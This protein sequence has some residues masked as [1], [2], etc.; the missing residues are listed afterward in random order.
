MYENTIRKLIEAGFGAA[1]DFEGATEAEIAAVEARFGRPLPGAY[2]AFL[3]EMGRRMGT[4]LRGTDIDISWQPP[5]NAYLADLVPPVSV[6]ESA[7]VF[8]SHQGYSL[9]A[10]DAA[11]GD[12]PLVFMISEGQ[13]EWRDLGQTFTQWIERAADDEIELKRRIGSGEL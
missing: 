11:T 13:P 8:L 12:D 7:F 2:R 5:F 4:F 3:A 10:F 9:A 6:P 1:G